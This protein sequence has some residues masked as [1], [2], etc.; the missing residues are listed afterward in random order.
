M[1]LSV[2][3]YTDIPMFYSDWFLRRLEKGYFCIS[4]G[5]NNNI[6]K[7]NPSNFEY[8]VFQTKNPQNFM[9]VINKLDKMDFKYLFLFTLT[10]YPENVE[11]NIGNKRE[12]IKTFK[13]LSN[14]IGKDKV[15]WKYGPIIINQTFDIDFHIRQFETLCKHLNRYTGECILSFIEEFDMPMHADLYVSDVSEDDKKKIIKSFYKIAKKHD[16]KLFC[17][18][19]FLSKTIIKNTKTLIGNKIYNVY[20]K[21]PNNYKTIDIGIKNTCLGDCEYCSCGGNNIKNS[22]HKLITEN[23]DS[24]VFGTVLNKSLP[25]KHPK[26]QHVFD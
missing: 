12:I 10:S 25:T 23:M 1:I 5:E 2:S 20:Q 13:N 3:K 14:K 26:I 11:K 15:V 4:D 6:Y 7:L 19:E 8:I 24:P 22:L 18:E 21:T 16:I 9:P 17:N